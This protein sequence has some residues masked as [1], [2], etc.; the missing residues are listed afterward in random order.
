MSTER[1]IEFFDCQCE[2]L[3]HAIRFSLEDHNRKG[4]WFAD[5][6]GL[7]ISVHLSQYRGFF[8]RLWNAAKYVLGVTRQWGDYDVTTLKDEDIGR[9][10][11]M[12]DEYHLARA[13]CEYNKLRSKNENQSAAPAVRAEE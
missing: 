6:V 10:R 1:R 2:V 9:L 4:E 7:N 13:K 5:S 12:I 11:D 8:G 3:P